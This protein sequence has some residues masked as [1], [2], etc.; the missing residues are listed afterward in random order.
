MKQKI[1]ITGASGGIGSAITKKFHEI[2]H[3][4]ILTSSSKEKLLKLIKEK[5]LTN[6]IS[7]NSIT[8]LIN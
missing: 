7:K 1:F 4:L 2:G 3:Q 8:N 6:D 5:N